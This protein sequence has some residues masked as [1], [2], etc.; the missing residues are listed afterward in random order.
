MLG[1]PAAGPG[2]ASVTGASAN[3]IGGSTGGYLTDIPRAPEFD[4]TLALRREG[5]LF[6]SNRCERLRSDAFRTRIMFRPVV[7][8]R[9][10]AAAEAFYG[11]D[12]F[13]RAGAIPPTVLMLLQDRGSVQ[14]LDGPAHRRR[15]QLFMSVMTPGSIAR[16]VDL[17]EDA[18]SLRQAAWDTRRDVVLLDELRLTLMQAACAWSG[19]ELTSREVRRRTHEAAE[20]IVGGGSVGPRNWRAL[21]LRSRAERWAR[22]MIRQ[23]RSGDAPVS[24]DSPLDHIASHHDVEGRQLTTKSAAVELLNLLRPIMAVSHYIVFAALALHRN[25]PYA[26]RVRTGDSRFAQAF[27]LEVRRHAPLFP[28]IGGRVKVPFEFL[29][30]RFSR[31]DWVLLDLYGTNHDARTWPQPD[32]FQPERFL[33]RVPS[34]FDLVPQGGGSHAATHRCAGEWAT[35]A[36]LKSAIRRLAGMR[37]AVPEQ[38]LTVDLSSFPALPKSGFAIR[39]GQPMS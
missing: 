34:A 36:L 28:A 9:G 33:D 8:M 16:L 35:E 11:E 2:V 37:Y 38:D 15:K 5:Y 19:L 23:V 30:H 32:A 12:R 22:R 26:E 7:C 20:M 18:W 14:F 25:P 27:A 6:I 10:S 29:G 39:I 3:S 17:F 24:R 4:G 21:V 31:G 13:T 1:E